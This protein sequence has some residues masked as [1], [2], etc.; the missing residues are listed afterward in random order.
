MHHFG[1]R[2]ISMDISSDKFQRF[3]ESVAYRERTGKRGEKA[4]NAKYF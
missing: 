1:V 3:F 2:V 4:E